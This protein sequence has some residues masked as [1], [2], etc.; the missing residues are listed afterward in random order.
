MMYPLAACTAV[1]A[2]WGLLKFTMAAPL[3]V[4]ISLPSS[5]FTELMVPQEENNDETSFSVKFIGREPI[6]MFVFAGGCWNRATG[7]ATGDLG[8]LEAH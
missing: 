6:Q 7:E 2:S 5:S 1:V 8:K 3:N 4:R